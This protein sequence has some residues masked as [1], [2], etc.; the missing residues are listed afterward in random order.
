MPT[1][2]LKSLWLWISALVVVLLA[3]AAML[4]WR[5]C[6]VD[7]PRC[8][9]CDGV[10]QAILRPHFRDDQWMRT[11]VLLDTADGSRFIASGVMQMRSRLSWFERLEYRCEFDSFLAQRD[12]E[13]LPYSSAG[14]GKLRLIRASE[15]AETLSQGI[16]VL[17]LTLPGFSFDHRGAMVFLAAE[18]QYSPG[19][20]PS[21]NGSLIYLKKTGG[22]W[23]IDQHHGLP[24]LIL[25]T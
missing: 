16:T 10:Y 1:R 24:H 7:A 3:G 6:R 4:I 18:R 9:E 14:Q 5:Q 21:F 23:I 2:L 19:I 8:P 12:G 17:T 22:Q 25:M 13:P 20:A 15:R 11:H